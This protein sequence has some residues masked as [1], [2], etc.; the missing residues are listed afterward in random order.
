MDKKF[1]KMWGFEFIKMEYFW[2]VLK[3]FKE[4]FPSN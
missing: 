1:T 3:K 4:N 2:R